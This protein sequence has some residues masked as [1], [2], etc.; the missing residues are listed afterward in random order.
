MK[1]CTWVNC[2]KSAMRPQIAKDG[3]VWATLCELH[4]F[5]I[6]NFDKSNVKEMLS[7]WVKAQGGAKKASQRVIK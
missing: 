4:H 3:E 1:N 6:N 7:F 5:K 2:K